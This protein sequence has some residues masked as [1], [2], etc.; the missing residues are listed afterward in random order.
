MGE[1]TFVTG[2][3]R[4]GKSSFAQR[5]AEASGDKRLFIA[6]APVLD[7]EM[8]TRVRRHREMRKELGW[9][10]IE[11]QHALADCFRRA[12]DYDVVLCDCLTL[13]VNNLLYRSYELGVSLEEEEIAA[14]SREVCY[15]ARSLKAR[16]FFVSN[17]VGMGI[18]PADEVSRRYRDLVGRCNQETAASSDSVVFVVSGLPIQLKGQAYGNF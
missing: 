16:V 11:E 17:E 1:I 8:E 6:T 7:Q 18:V 10:T 15:A 4:S 3:C 9:D 14:R 12:G 13:W 2:G 5:L